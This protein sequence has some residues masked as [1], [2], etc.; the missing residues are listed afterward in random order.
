MTSVHEHR[1]QSPTSVSCAVI[2]VSDTRT[3]ATDTSG[4]LIRDGLEGAGHMVL[5]SCIVPDEPSAIRRAIE[6]AAA[7]G[8]VKAI[9]LTGGTGITPRDRT[10]EVVSEML[11]KCMDG[12]GEL[13]RVFSYE[14]IGAAAMLSRAVGGVAKGALVFAMPGSRAAVRL[15]M[16][17]LILPDLGHLVFEMEK[18]PDKKE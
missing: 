7:T 18:R 8:G 5:S 6:E 16:E 4:Q 10:H 3:E 9:L 17:K 11:D 1:A 2:T 12:F 14:E 15:A 13:F